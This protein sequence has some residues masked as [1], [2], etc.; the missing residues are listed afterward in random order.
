MPE[1]TDGHDGFDAQQ[2][3]VVSQRRSQWDALIWQVP[4]LGF[5]A[6][7]FLLTIA[8]S[9]GN[10][11]TARIV[12]S[13]LA[14]AVSACC[15][16]LMARHRLCEAVDAQWL[17]DSDEEQHLKPIQGRPFEAQLDDLR[18]N[19]RFLEG[20]RWRKPVVWLAQFR[21]TNVWM[22][23]MAAFGVAAAVSLVLAI[24]K[25]SLLAGTSLIVPAT[26]RPSTL[27]AWWYEVIV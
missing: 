11:R 22:L 14:L 1:D 6:Q 23:A 2:Y 18:R 5:T 21:S 17:V 24:V 13:L 15:L 9:G 19:E 20:E 27:S 8:L 3:S 12:A 26:D 25:P 4:V 10:T 7:A 16:Q